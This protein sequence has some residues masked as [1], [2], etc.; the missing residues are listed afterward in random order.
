[1]GDNPA[2]IDRITVKAARELV[3]VGVQRLVKIPDQLD[4]ERAAGLTVTYG[5][6]LYA[7]RERASRRP[8][9]RRRG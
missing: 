1:M 8:R 2:F 7:L 6:T 5:T 4:F 9:P 3:A